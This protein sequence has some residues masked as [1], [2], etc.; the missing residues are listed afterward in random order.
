MQVI[1]NTDAILERGRIVAF[2][3]SAPIDTGD[4]LEIVDRKGNV[5]NVAKVTEVRH[6]QPGAYQNFMLKAKVIA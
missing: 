4:T 3:S 6:T 2:Q 1:S 5:L